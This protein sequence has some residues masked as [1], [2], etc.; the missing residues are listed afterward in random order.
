M[1]LHLFFDVF[2]EDAPLGIYLR[3]DQRRF[4]VD[5]KVRSSSEAYKYQTKF[6]ITR[7]SLISYEN[8]G[9]KS[10]TIRIEC[11]NPE[12]CSIY[13]EMSSYFPNSSIKKERSDTAK[14]YY[15]AL[16][17]LEIDDK[18]WIFFSPNNDHP[19]IGCAKTLSN[20]IQ[21]AD[22]AAERTGAEIVSI[23]YSHFTECQNFFKPSHHEW[24]AY[25]NIFPKLLYETDYSFVISVNKKLLD[26]LHIYRLGDLKR[27]FGESKKGGRIIRPED[28]EFYLKDTDS[29]VMVVPKVEFCRHYDGYMHIADKVPPLFIPNGFFDRK[30]KIRYGY[31]NNI[32]GFV[33]I[34]PTCNKFSYQHPD[35]PDLK[36][37]L[38]D[39]PPF[40]DQRISQLDVNPSFSRDLHNR[41]IKYYEELKNPWNGTLK[42]FNLALSFQRLVKYFIKK[43]I[44]RIDC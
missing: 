20:V 12:H 36:N 5:H 14:K 35:G 15:D 13:E 8:I 38:E 32:S 10:V 17:A 40:W 33:N 29:H 24:G 28:T 43:K 4:N 27:I 18:E 7:Y 6:D 26:S 2:I 34:N 11:Q 42:I 25:G 19:F 30:I 22:D 16:N 1:N 21:D 44:R 37:L 41:D 3:G 23:P 9:W 39:I 31:S